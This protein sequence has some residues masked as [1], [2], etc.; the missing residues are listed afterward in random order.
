[1]ARGLKGVWK[2]GLPKGEPD[3]SR[4]QVADCVV[5]DSAPVGG[6]EALEVDDKLTRQRL[7]KDGIEF[8]RFRTRLGLRELVDHH[9]VIPAGG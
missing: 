7:G 8:E 6:H 5:L 2:V 9:L 1:M 4:Q 3:D